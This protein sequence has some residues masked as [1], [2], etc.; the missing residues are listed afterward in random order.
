MSEINTKANYTHDMVKETGACNISVISKDASFELFKHFGFQ[1]G[2]N[3]DKLSP[4]L[5]DLLAKEISNGESIFKVADNG[6]PYITAGTNA[7]NNM[8]PL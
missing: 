1:S 4:D 3:V 2:R 5:L 7:Y 8:K 6:I